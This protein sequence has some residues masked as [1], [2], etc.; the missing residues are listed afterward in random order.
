MSKVFMTIFVAAN[1]SLNWFLLFES[2]CSTDSKE[3]YDSY[4][5]RNFRSYA[6]VLMETEMI[7]I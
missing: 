3:F 5:S 1:L 4:A 2:L 7:L 6:E